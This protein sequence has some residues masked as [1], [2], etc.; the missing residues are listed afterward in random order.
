MSYLLI[1]NSDQSKY[2]S[3]GNGLTIQYSMKNHQYPKYLILAA[4][5]MKNHWHDNSIMRKT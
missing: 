1:V 3:L 4:D 5:I 2:D